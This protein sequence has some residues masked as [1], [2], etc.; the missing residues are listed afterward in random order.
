MERNLLIALDDSR[1]SRLAAKYAGAFFASDQQVRFDLLNIQP[2]LSDFLVEEAKRKASARQKLDRLYRENTAHAKKILADV[3]EALKQS[4]IAEERIETHP[5]PYNQGKAKDIL[6]FATRGRF[7]AIV[8]GRRGVSGWQDMLFGSVSNNIIQQSQVLPVWMVDG[9]PSSGKILVPVDGSSHSLR[10][11]DHLAFILAGRQDNELVFFHVQPKLRQYCTIDF[12][13]A[14]AEPLEELVATGD[15]QCI[16]NFYGQAKKKLAEAGIG[17]SQFEIKTN[18]GLSS[19]GSQIVKELESGRYQTVVMGRS[20][21]S[22]NYFM[23]SVAQQVIGKAT[24]C[25]VWIVP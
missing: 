24:D 25:A 10:A 23:G 12:D 3:A 13:S 15:R 16:D 22:R 14:T 7:D 11:V 20:G 2:P 9:Q 17:E 5:L 21:G 19:V 4:G 6:D 18:T 8:L 1:H